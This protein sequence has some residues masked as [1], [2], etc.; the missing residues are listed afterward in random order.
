MMKRSVLFTILLVCLLCFIACAAAEESDW[1]YEIINSRGSRSVRIKKYNPAGDPPEVLV[2]PDELGGYPVKEIS[3]YAFSNYWSLPDYKSERM[4]GSRVIILPSGIEKIEPG[5]YGFDELE[6]FR[7]ENNSYY[8]TVDGVL[9]QSA[10]H[11]LLAY[12]KGRH[13]RS[14]TVPEGT[15]IIGSRAFYDPEYLNE[16]WLAE[17]VRVIKEDAFKVFRLCLIIRKGI[18]TIESEAVIWASQFISS[19]PRFKVY[20]DLLI[21]TEE[22]R[23]ISVG[24]KDYLT[25]DEAHNRIINVPEGVE[26]IAP[27][28]FSSIT[29]GKVNLPSTLK[30]VESWNDFSGSPTESLIFPEGLERIGM[31]CSASVKALVFPST[32]KSMD[33]NCFTHMEDLE[34]VFFAEGAETIGYQCF[35]S[36]PNLESVTLPQSLRSI[37]QSQYSYEKEKEAFA[38]CPK[39]CAVV[40]P[41][42]AAEQFCT[43]HNIL[44]RLPFLGQ[45]QVNS[46]EAEAVLS[47]PGADDVLIRLDLDKLELTYNLDGS[48]HLETFPIEWTDGQLRM[49]GGYMLYEFPDPE[50]LILKPGSMELNLIKVEDDI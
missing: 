48:R 36:N 19:S 35:N 8:E 29:C 25:W 24:G 12:P 49:E 13:G 34:S 42:S 31:S 14:Y 4:P 37:G 18:E 44:Y 50:H 5:Q 15:E 20:D 41:G 38:D 17:S 11:T 27:K 21:D 43:G 7:I 9:F 1:Q 45:W 22:N 26:I 32:L 16:V 47:L 46:A 40:M 10:T 28:A 23:L 30:T 3:G 39:L 33:R 2:V 6:E